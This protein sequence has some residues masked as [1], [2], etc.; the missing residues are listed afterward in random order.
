MICR[1]MILSALPGHQLELSCRVYI[2]S[3]IQNQEGASYLFILHLLS[4]TWFSGRLTGR[5]ARLL[6]QLQMNTLPLT[7]LQR[8]DGWPGGDA[9]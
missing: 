3:R 9:Q 5:V 8:E 7:L 6:K 2:C 4:P 1:S